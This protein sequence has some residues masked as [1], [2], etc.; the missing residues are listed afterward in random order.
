MTQVPPPDRPQ[1]VVPVC[2]RHPRRETHV[3]CTRCDRPICPDCM[4]E[5]S[6]GHQCPECVAEGR[7]DPAAGAGPSS[8]ARRPGRS[9]YVTTGLIG[10]NVAGR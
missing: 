3:R 1:P 8:A 4:T 9:G 2:Y 10:I 7:R 5:A 6:V